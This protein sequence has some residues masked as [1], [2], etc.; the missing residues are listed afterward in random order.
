MI[1]DLSA[2]KTRVAKLYLS[3]MLPI[4][5]KR[6][7]ETKR[8]LPLLIYH[9]SHL[10]RSGGYKDHRG[11]TIRMSV[12]ACSNI[13]GLQLEYKERESFVLF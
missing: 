13:M 7:V 6:N 12:F 8:I 4:L 1:N 5:C 9:F 11:G 10:E 2:T 3:A